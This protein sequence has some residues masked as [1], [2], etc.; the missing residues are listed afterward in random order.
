MDKNEKLTLSYFTLSDM[1]NEAQQ[2]GLL[3]DG[4]CYSLDYDI[5]E[6]IKRNIESGDIKMVE[7]Y[8]NGDYI[9]RQATIA[10]IHELKMSVSGYDNDALD[11]SSIYEVLGEI[12][13]ADVQPVKRGKWK[14]VALILNR[15]VC[16]NCSWRTDEIDTFDFNFCPNCGA[17]MEDK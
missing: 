3:A 14:R 2:D 4:C 13:T 8:N 7:D 15:S 9:S 17:K 10:A 1:L 12:P 11:V 6:E 16:S 5:D